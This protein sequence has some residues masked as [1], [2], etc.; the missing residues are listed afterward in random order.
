M[1]AYDCL[2]D[3]EGLFVKPGALGNPFAEQA[4]AIRVRIGDFSQPPQV[5]V[6]ATGDG[7]SLPVAPVEAIGQMRAAPAPV[8]PIEVLEEPVVAIERD[9][10]IQ[11]AT[12]ANLFLS[13]LLLLHVGSGT[14]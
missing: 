13:L 3:G 11:G 8:L 4:V 2:F 5:M 10:S 12:P 14:S 9:A 6:G 7:A 1:L